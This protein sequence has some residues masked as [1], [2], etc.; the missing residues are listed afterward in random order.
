MPPQMKPV[1]SLSS[2]FFVTKTG[3]RGSDVERCNQDSAQQPAGA[4]IPEAS[5]CEQ[6]P[7]GDTAGPR[8]HQPYTRQGLAAWSPLTDLVCSHHESVS[9]SEMLLEVCRCGVLIAQMVNGGS[10]R[11]RALFRGQSQYCEPGSDISWAGHSYVLDS[12]GQPGGE[13]EPGARPW[14]QRSWEKGQRWES[15]RGTEKK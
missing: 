2:N 3:E 14:G 7:P 12:L 8:P 9:L 11:I 10:D 5:S 1:S 15:E 6:W 4:G 13:R